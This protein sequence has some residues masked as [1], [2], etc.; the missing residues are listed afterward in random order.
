[1]KYV[2]LGSSG[3]KV[4]R[5]SLGSWHLPL[6]G[7]TDETGVHLVDVDLFKR[8]VAKAV[9]L[10]INFFDTA[11]MYHG[12]MDLADPSHAGNAE[13]ILGEVLSGYDRESLVVATK[14]F[15][16]MAGHP[17]GGGLSRKHIRW[18]IRES[19]NRLRTSYVDLYFLH[20]PDPET[21]LEESLETLADLVRWGL[22]D[23]A[24]LSNFD[25]MDISFAAEYSKDLHL[26]LVAI[27][28][29]YNLFQRET[30]RDKFWL[31]KNYGL[32]VM[33]YSPLAQ[34]VLTGKYV[35]GIPAGSR[36]SY[37]TEMRDRLLTP[38]DLEASAQ[39]VEMAKEKGITAAQLALAWM[40]KV[41]EEWGITVIPIVGATKISHLED[42]VAALDVKLTGDDMKRLDEISRRARVNFQIT[43]RKSG[44]RPR[45]LRRR[46][47]LRI[48]A[49]LFCFVLFCFVS[50][51]FIF[52]FH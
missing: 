16:K 23:Y 49:I 28:E 52:R 47:L 33:S 5:L 30:E 22:I 4:S 43:Y 18:Q 13:K 32:A 48:R 7:E 24:G 25:P 50:L 38:E 9:D 17:N 6:T 34:G 29:P 37:P 14:V 51:L 10:G 8:V 20:W 11:N 3:L 12:A 45:A 35:G 1:L 31:A 21:P 2:N 42:D 19:L 44:R 39:L 41:G 40:L 36:G 27:Q 26:P 46:F 15:F